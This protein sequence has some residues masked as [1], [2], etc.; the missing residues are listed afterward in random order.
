MYF[1]QLHSLVVKFTFFLMICF[2]FYQTVVVSIF[3]ILSCY[4]VLWTDFTCFL[5]SSYSLISYVYASSFHEEIS[6]WN[7]SCEVLIEIKLASKH[8]HSEKLTWFFLIVT[9]IIIGPNIYQYCMLTN[10]VQGTE[11][12]FNLPVHFV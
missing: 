8:Q 2:L 10:H 4:L 1:Y 3:E 6:K 12:E 5:T 9:S 11:F 7:N